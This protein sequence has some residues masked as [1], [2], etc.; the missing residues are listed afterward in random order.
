MQ[1]PEPTT[2]RNVSGGGGFVLVLVSAATRAE[3]DRYGRDKKLV[4]TFCV[5]KLRTPL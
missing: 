5:A 4:K 2:L 1:R 3:S